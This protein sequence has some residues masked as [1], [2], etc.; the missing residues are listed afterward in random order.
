MSHPIVNYTQ[1]WATSLH[2]P[3]FF[4]LQTSQFY[5]AKNFICEIKI[6]A[7][8]TEK[9]GERQKATTNDEN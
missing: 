1:F 5:D 9:H 4:H 6:F 8:A 2:I 7:I 3:N